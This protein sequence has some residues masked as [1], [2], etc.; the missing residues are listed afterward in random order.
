MPRLQN[1]N[2][3]TRS[4][5]LDEPLENGWRRVGLA[6]EHAGIGVEDRDRANGTYFV[7]ILPPV[8]KA[9]FLDSLAF[10]RSKEVPKPVRYQVYVHENATGCEVTVKDEN[11]ENS[12][13]AQQVLDT[14]YQ[15]LGK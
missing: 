3:G 14:L 15:S 11:A 2:G 13:A 8:R 7:N 6:L 9:G 12:P 10:W 5:L 1:L 4:I